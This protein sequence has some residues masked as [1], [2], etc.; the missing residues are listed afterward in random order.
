MLRRPFVLLSLL[1]LFAAVVQASVGAFSAAPSSG[2]ADAKVCG[3][4]GP[5][6]GFCSVETSDEDE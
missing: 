5:I 6:G 4:C 3:A 2:D 1:I